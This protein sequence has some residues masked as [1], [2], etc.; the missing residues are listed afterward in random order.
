[1]LFGVSKSSLCPDTVSWFDSKHWM[2][3]KITSLDSALLVSDK[4]W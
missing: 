4:K 3:N 2:P 1:M